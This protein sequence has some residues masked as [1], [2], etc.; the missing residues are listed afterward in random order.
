M[1]FSSNK[2]VTS[3]M[4]ASSTDDDLPIA[5]PFTSRRQWGVEKLT[6]SSWKVVHVSSL[7][8]GSQPSGPPTSSRDLV[9]MQ[10]AH[11]YSRVASPSASHDSYL[12]GILANFSIPA[13]VELL[14]LPEDLPQVVRWHEALEKIQTFF[15]I[16]A[17][18]HKEAHLVKITPFLGPSMDLRAGGIVGVGRAS[19]EDSTFISIL[20]RGDEPE[21]EL[22]QG[23]SG[24]SYHTPNISI[25]EEV[26]A[27]N[28]RVGFDPHPYVACGGRGSLGT[29]LYFSNMALDK[30][31]QSCYYLFR[32]FA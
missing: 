1:F 24:G 15:S 20:R 23:A 26:A 10:A 6:A 22:S 14:P 9:Q 12:P 17:T 4:G 19:G 7:P 3:L 28:Y 31:S 25:S 30:R 2:Y 16:D 13:T 29:A 32:A 5:F 8:E 11:A 18:E 21:P 27:R